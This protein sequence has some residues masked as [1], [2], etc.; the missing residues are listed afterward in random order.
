MLHILLLI[1]KI[2]GIILAVILGILVLLVCIVLF[3]PIRYEC[4]G[5]CK[6]NIDTIKIRGKVTWLFH[7]VMADVYFKE[8]KLRWRIRIAWKKITGGES[9]EK[10]EENEKNDEKS[11]ETKE[12]KETEKHQKTESDE[13]PPEKNEENCEK[14]EESQ[15]ECK[16]ITETVEKEEPGDKEKC[17]PDEESGSEKDSKSSQWTERISEKIKNI[18]HN[19]KCTI[20]NICDKI[21]ALSEK[22]EK[23][24]DF[25]QNEI[26]VNAFLKVKSEAFKIIKKFKPK[27]FNLKVRFGFEDPQRTGQALAFFAVLY[28][29]F[30]DN[31]EVIPDFE[32]RI[33]KG[34]IHVKGRIRCC[35]LVALACRLLLCRNIRITYK[36][37]KNFEL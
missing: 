10:S 16:K 26:H 5:I 19:I 3:V 31:I 4:D 28:P 2:I 1:L 12:I 36:D 27:E 18:Y 33:L 11:N 9:F 29:F 23:L 7:L 21:K 35:H 14:Q 22:K 34:K 6:G 8:K 30:E 25:I 32:K 13:K 24:I 20:Q 37:I 17:E 15:K